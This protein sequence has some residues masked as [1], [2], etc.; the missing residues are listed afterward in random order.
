[1]FFLQSYAKKSKEKSE[2]LLKSVKIAVFL[3]KSF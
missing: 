1:L 2:K 3:L